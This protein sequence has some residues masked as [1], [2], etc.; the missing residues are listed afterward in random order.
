MPRDAPDRATRKPPVGARDYSVRELRNRAQ[1]LGSWLGSSE[2]QALQKR[3]YFLTGPAGCGKTHLFLNSVRRALEENRPAVVLFGGRFGHGDLWASVCD[4]LGLE[5]LGSDLL[6]G[7]MDAAGEA[8]AERG[9]RFLILIDALNEAI[10]PDFWTT[11]LPALRSSISRWP[12]VALAVSCRDTYLDV[13]DEGLERSHYVEKTHPG[14]AGREVEATHKYFEHYGL[15][16]PRIPLLAPEFSVPLFLRLYC[17]GLRDSGTTAAALGHEGRVRIFERYL[18][19]KLD[20]VARRLRPNASTSYELVQ[21]RRRASGAMDALLDEFA[22]KGRES[23][24]IERAEQL[25]TSALGGRLDEAV[26]LLGALQSEFVLTREVLFIGDNPPTEGLR[27]IFQAFADYLILRRRLRSVP[28]P[29]TDARFRRWLESECS[30]GVIE[31]A[32]VV[33]PELCGVELPDLL[34]IDASIDERKGDE[35]SRRARGRARNTFRT[36]IRTLPYRA[37]SAVTQRSIDLLNE[38]L[39]LVS[40]NDLFHT[41]FLIAPQPDNRLNAETLHRYLMRHRMPRR[42]AFFGFATYSEIWEEASPAA[43]LARWASLGPYPSYEPKVVEL[44]SVPLVWLLSSPNRF[45]RDWVT[46]ALV[47][48]LRGHLDVMQKLLDRFWLVGD[49]YIV[50]RVVVVAYGAL[51][52]SNSVDVAKA[53][54]LVNRVRELVFTPPIRADEIMLD[55]ARGIVAW[56][57]EKKIVTRS[58]LVDTRRPYGLARPGN[59]PSESSLNEKY[60]FKK[61]QPAEGSYNTVYYSVMSMGDFGRKVIEPGISHFSRFK[62]GEAIPKEEAWHPM[63]VKSR[64]KVFVRSLSEA[65]RSGLE[66]ATSTET[67]RSDS[68]N[69][70]ESWEPALGLSLTAEQRDLLESCLRQPRRQIRDDRYPSDRARRWVFRRTLSLG[71]TPSLFGREDYICRA[72]RCRTAQGGALGQEVPMD[73]ISRAVG[74]RSRQLPELRDVR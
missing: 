26:L 27:I 43:T 29:R 59:P 63:I 12:H 11:H 35:A 9:H 34:E 1:E 8:S 47:Q 61:N 44:A 66:R 21:A 46:K 28:D 18:D 16:A 73:G 14:F 17:E 22:E 4:Q 39:R 5:P 7:A 42:D 15:E 67:T 37:S 51:M 62:R 57:V 68:S 64:W 6:L 58:A 30:W 19:A 20:R 33:L 23:I 70:D 55:A 71:W 52:R 69:A 3:L 36:L 60:G 24:S 13:V 53:K 32:A 41:L 48:L 56:G 31:A 40:P 65:Q 72:C 45:M 38:G 50:Q 49:P 10:P 74:A 54:R 2:G 25:A